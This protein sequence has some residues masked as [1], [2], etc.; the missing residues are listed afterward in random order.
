MAQN[1]PK[2][3]QFTTLEAFREYLAKEK[4]EI[5]LAFFL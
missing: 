5:D 2:I 1:Y 4:I 3:A